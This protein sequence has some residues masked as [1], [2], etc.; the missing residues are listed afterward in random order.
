MSPDEAARKSIEIFNDLYDELVK[1]NSP[2][3]EVTDVHQNSIEFNFG[4]SYFLLIISPNYRIGMLYGKI[5]YKTQLQDRPLKHMPDLD[6]CRNVRS[7]HWQ[8]AN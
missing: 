5:Y 8:W 3:F 4:I 1:H 7:D 6:F 2:S